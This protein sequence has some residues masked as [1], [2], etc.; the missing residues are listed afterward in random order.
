MDNTETFLS[1]LKKSL[2]SK[3]TAKIIR[4]SHMKG[5]LKEHLPQVDRLFD[6]PE[7]LDFHP[8]GNAG[9]HIISIRRTPRCC[10]HG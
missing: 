9:M 2:E 8:E 7:R 3:D 1:L 4:L 6:I 10:P 5:E